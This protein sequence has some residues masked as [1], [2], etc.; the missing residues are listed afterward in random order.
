MA[1]RFHTPVLLEEAVGS[2]GCKPHGIYVDGT[3]GGGGHAY[4]I[5]MRTALD[6]RLIGIDADQDA[7]DESEKKLE[8]F[9]QRKILI[10][11]NFSQIK[12]VLAELKIDKVNGIL[13]DLGVSSHQFETPER[14][15]SFVLD[16]PLDMRID[17]SRTEN[18][19][20]LIHTLSEK[21][22][23]RIIREY[24]EEGDGEEDCQRHCGQQAYRSDSH[25]RSAG[26]DYYESDAFSTKEWPDSPSHQDIS[27]LADCS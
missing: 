26:G 1:S 23:A 20:D 9:G 19:Y 4:E 6:G 11:A 3:L 18:V 25:D 16:A 10:R 27:G 13:L 14:G 22:L 12:E 15:F 7:L 8:A 2:L 17:Q 24:G 5:L 21:D